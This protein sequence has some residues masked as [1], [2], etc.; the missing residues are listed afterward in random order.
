MT[1]LIETMTSY[2]PP[3][4]IRHLLAEPERTPHLANTDAAVFFADV[5]GFT[6]LT[7]QLA[8]LGPEGAEEL[9]RVLNAYFGQ[10]IEIITRHGG[11]VIKFAGDALLALWIVTPDEDLAA[12]T[13]RAAHCGLEVQARLRDYVTTGLVAAPLHLRVG[14]GAGEI[15]EAHL[16]GRLGKWEY[17]VAGEPLSQMS[18]AEHQAQPGDVVLSA[19]AWRLIE[20]FC[21]GSERPEGCLRLERV[22]ESLPLVP[23]AP[24]VLDDHAENLVRS[25]LPGAI[26]AR[27]TAGQSGWLAELRRV[28]VIFLNLPRLTENLNLEQAQSVVETLQECIYYYEGSINKIGVD[29]KGA[30]LIA[31]FGL[32]PFAHEDDALRGVQAAILMQ[33]RLEELGVE[34]SIGITTGRVFCGS[35]GSP[36]RREYTMMGDSVNLSA[37]LMQA[38]AGTD[39]ILCDET[40]YQGAKSRINFEALPLLKVKGKASKIAAFR[41]LG[42]IRQQTGRQKT[43]IVGRVAERKLLHGLARELKEG[44]QGRIVVIEAEAGLGKSRLLEDLLDYAEAQG[45]VVYAGAGDSIEQNS[46]YHAWRPI[47]AQL[48]GLPTVADSTPE[49]RRAFVLSQLESLPDLAPLA[50]LLAAVLPFDWA[51]NAL[52][53]QMNGQVRAENTLTLLTGILREVA[54][55]NSLLIAIEDGHWLDSASWALLRVAAREVQPALFVLATRPLG[56]TPPPEY[57]ALVNTPGAR[58]VNLETMRPEE[59]LALISHRLG[60][61]SLPDEVADFIQNK[62]EGHPFF[63][64]ELAYALRDT[65]VL[66]IADSVA[67]LAPGTTDL[68]S[69]SFPDTVQGVIT[70]RIDRLGAAEQFALKVASVI[71]RV[72]A[73]RTLQK[74]H[75]IEDDRPHLRRYMQTLENL[76][77]TPLDR[78]DPDLVYFFKH[79]ITQE[80]AYNLML[81]AQRREL[82]RL[83]AEW[84]E[85]HQKD[86]LA[87]FYPTLAYHWG[88]A[89]NSAKAV[90]YLIKAGEQAHRNY[91]NQEAIDFLLEALT[92]LPETDAAR[93]AHCEMLI[94]EAYYRTG[95]MQQSKEHLGRAVTLLGFPVPQGMRA[96][97]TAVGQQ[98]F[99]QLVHR[100]QPGK[101]RKVTVMPQERE[102]YLKVIRTYETL[103]QIY[104]FENDQTIISY[105]TFLSLNL[106]EKVEPSSELARSYAIMS[107]V[108][109]MLV[110]RL[111]ETYWQMAVNT[112]QKVNEDA[113]IAMVSEILGVAG[114]SFGWWERAREMFSTSLELSRKLADWKRYE[115]SANVLALVYLMQGDTQTAV[116]FSHDALKSAEA[117]GDDHTRTYS[118]L[119]QAQAAL[120]N[121]E[122]SRALENLRIADNPIDDNPDADRMFFY[123]LLAQTHLRREHLGEAHAAARQA[124]DIIQS[125]SS[126]TTAYSLPAFVGAADFYLTAYERNLQLPDEKKSNPELARAA[127]KA[128]SSFARL[129]P[130]ARSSALRCEGRYAWLT[131]H[132]ERAYRLGERAADTARKLN[133]PYKEALA[134]L[135]LVRQLPPGS[136]RRHLHIERAR[137][138]LTQLKA[139]Y[140]LEQLEQLLNR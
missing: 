66:Q 2:L 137:T 91:A 136:A 103:G 12:K 90:V 128:L 94:G 72:F 40:T 71:G 113:A 15:Y 75:P 69:I 87:A 54:R 119:V 43:A 85:S 18:V 65:G 56:A 53:A 33:K 67:Q 52:T 11:E 112:A 57:T 27:L 138:L 84:F 60:V 101:Y 81:Y 49:D 105:I 93:R 39:D 89:E 10:L 29:D 59:V 23:A 115:E 107:F 97:G 17:V 126:H 129:F 96:L 77:L 135:E 61:S 140:E 132:Y 14:I 74:V 99:R 19:T 79:I 88:K 35:V 37:R 4:V 82:H 46:T 139:D 121:G 130:I 63:S 28:T 127:C 134:H 98:A 109:G 1:A 110:P 116:K 108:I 22:L 21:A 117:R 68:A 118:R 102:L 111:G 7:E 76:D 114:F 122:L 36:Q 16:G 50:P 42:E 55:T 125:R 62:A 106:G 20:K 124:L 30:T 48:F 41:P 95:R 8:R 25:Y 13:R 24:P 26:L 32:P 64:E 80:V 5:S 45:L 104:Y 92:L 58:R 3:V 131:G 70:S 123:G 73:L 6:S 51:D 83:T 47:F 86:D 9:T 78:P 133:M 44:A 38:A 120:M 31:A 34:N 100:L